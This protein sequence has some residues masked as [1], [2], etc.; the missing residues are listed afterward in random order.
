VTNAYLMYYWTNAKLIVQGKLCYL[1]GPR[2]TELHR[3]F[4]SV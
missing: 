1:L 2:G 3:V 4:K